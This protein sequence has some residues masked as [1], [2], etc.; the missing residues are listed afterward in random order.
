MWSRLG[1]PAAAA[2]FTATTVLM[3][4][5]ALETYL[6]EEFDRVGAR[7]EQF[8]RSGRVDEVVWDARAGSLLV[9]FETGHVAVFA[10]TSPNCAQ[11]E[12]MSAL[13]SLVCAAQVRP[14][15]RVELT[16]CLERWQYLIVADA[17]VID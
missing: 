11:I 9:R 4:E 16:A 7:V 5:W 2:G 8:N 14:D 13:G 17:L 12:A 6:A 10:S 15:G 1:R 3:M